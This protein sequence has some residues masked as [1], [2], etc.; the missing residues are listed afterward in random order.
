MFLTAPGS[1]VR[2][3]FPLGLVF[4]AVMIYF[5]LGISIIAEIF[6]SAIE[7]V[8]S[9]KKKTVT[10][11]GKT[12]TV[13]LWNETVATLT[14]MALGSSAP[15]IFLAMIETFKRGFHSGDLGPSTIVGS[16]SFNLFVIV[17]VCIVAIPAGEVRCIKNMRA[18]FVTA[19]FSICAYGWMVIVLVMHTKDVIDVPEA[20]ITLFGLPLLVWVSYSV[21]VGFLL[22]VLQRY[23]FVEEEEDNKIR[24]P[25]IIGF[26]NPTMEV[27]GSAEE[28]TVKA[29]VVRQG[30]LSRGV[31]CTY[32]TEKLTAVPEYDFEETAGRL[33]FAVGQA[34]TEIEIKV[35][36]KS[37]STVSREFLVILEDAEGEGGAD[38]DP[39]EDGREDSAIL[40]I[41]ITQ[42]NLITS[43]SSG[44]SVGVV[45][46]ASRLLDAAVNKNNLKLATWEWCMQIVG[47]FYANG[48]AE[49]QKEASLLDWVFHILAFPW[50]ITFAIL[51]PPTLYAGGWV[52]FVFAIG[53]IGLL[54]GMV[55]DIAEMFGCLLDIP[56]IVTAVTFVALGTS[57]P[58]LFASVSAAQADP[59]AD[60]SIVNVTGSNSVN[61]FL[62]LG[63]PWCAAAIYWT[64]LAERDFEW[65]SRYPEIAKKYKT[66][67]VFVVESRNL[68]F[69]V[70]AF[71]GLCCVAI[72]LLVLR[73]R[74]GGAEL[75]GKKW[76]KWFSAVLMIVLWLDFVVLAGWRV[77]RCEGASEGHWCK[78]AVWEQMVVCGTVAAFTVVFSAPP[79]YLLCR[80]GRLKGNGRRDAQEHSAGALHDKERSGGRNSDRHK[81]NSITPVGKITSPLRNTGDSVEED[82]ITLRDFEPMLEA[83]PKNMQEMHMLQMGD[84][85]TRDS[86]RKAISFGP[87]RPVVPSAHAKTHTLVVVIVVAYHSNGRNETVFN[88]KPLTPF[89]RVIEAWCQYHQLPAHKTAF[90]LKHRGIAP[91]DTPASLGHDPSKTTTMVVNAKPRGGSEASPAG[92]GAR[93]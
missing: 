7:T 75:G 25:H 84:G 3:D 92:G 78:A 48:S 71:T 29:R 68:G 62:G 45:T 74:Y 39:E 57:M 31:V 69:C 77:M 20:V 86:L 59:T 65:E 44:N 49:E 73:R 67:T 81:P 38:F 56:D 35:L 79:M 64:Y 87:S 4:G 91:D 46:G 21:D 47:A 1:T 52:C 58:D 14:L 6:M 43:A 19:I 37:V 53:M 12:F 33:E 28:Q 41:R 2:P 5:F 60:A 8:T 93:Q 16:A 72:I 9:R 26:E 63:I 42:I 76:T 27:F 17:A 32:R 51:V 34:E 54:S 30:G 18:F 40:T 55:S 22:G 83:T 50:K 36:P 66:G 13:H 61:V 82:A 24:D 80:E 89:R 70:L 11:E 85:V 88:V 10:K 15:E 90:T 23:G